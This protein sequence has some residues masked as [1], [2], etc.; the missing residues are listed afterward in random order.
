MKNGRADIS[1]TFVQ[2]FLAHTTKTAWTFNLNTESTY[3][4]K[5]NQWSV[6]VNFTVAKLV[7]FGH[8]PVSLG[9][10][11]RYWAEGP[12]AGPHGWGYRLF[13][14]FLFPK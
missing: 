3:D 10:G 6:P 5:T 9:G 13:A 11:V 4:W 1:S 2:P 14:T 12:E 8:Q 7:K